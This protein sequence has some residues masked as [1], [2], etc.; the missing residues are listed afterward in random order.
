MPRSIAITESKNKYAEYLARNG[1]KS[2]VQRDL[3]INEFFKSKG[4]IS[5]EELH[6]KLRGKH[7]SI[8]L[9]TVY[10]T[11]KVLANAGLA[12]ERQ[13]ND[14][15]TRYEFCAPDDRHHDHIVCL[16]C[17]LVEEFENDEIED[18]QQKVADT[19]NFKITDHRLEIYGVCA[20]CQAKGEN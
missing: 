5:V 2:T 7:S 14:G 8:G 18:L 16:E 17:G 10:R 20:G 15:F 9:A 4:H 6:S 3:I 1:L 13:F 12:H 11:L 19:H